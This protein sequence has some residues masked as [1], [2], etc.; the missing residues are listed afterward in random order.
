MTQPTLIN[1]HPNEYR[2]E[3]HCYCYP[4]P[5]KLDRF[6]ISCNTFNDKSAEV[7]VPNKTEALNLSVFNRITRIKD[8]KALTKHVSC[9]CRCKFY[10]RKCN[11]NQKW[12]NDQYRC[13]CKKHYI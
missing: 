5:V 3:L 2:Y 12:N 13:E 8:S 6:V 10:C 7:C 9:K 1:L 4:Y 11:S